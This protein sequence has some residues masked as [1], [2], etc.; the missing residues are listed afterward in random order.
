MKREG[1]GWIKNLS[2][3]VMVDSFQNYEVFYNDL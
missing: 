3:P 2:L 1:R